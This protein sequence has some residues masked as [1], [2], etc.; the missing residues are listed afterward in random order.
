MNT[1]LLEHSELIERLGCTLVHSLW[2]I[3]VVAAFLLVGRTT[4]RSPGAR[5]ALAMLALTACVVGPVMTFVSMAPVAA[6]LE[7]ATVVPAPVVTGEPFQ[8]SAPVVAHGLQTKLPG[9]LSPIAVP[10]VSWRLRL[11]HGLP[12]AVLAWFVGMGCFVVRHLGGLWSLHTLRT[13]GL[14]PVSAE[15]KE[16]F[17]QTKARLGVRRL[18]KVFESA[19][20]LTP[21]V[22]GTL[23]PV[24]LLPCSALTGL[25]PREL[26]ALLTHEIAHLR[27]WD[28]LANFFQCAVETLLFF[29]PALWWISRKVRE[30]RELCCDDLAVAQGV[31][32][33][34]LAHALGHMALW[35]TEAL[36][37]SLAATG[38]M[39]VLARIK[40]LL[41]HPPP[42]PIA[43]N[44][45]PLAALLLLVAG[46]LLL[47]P[48]TKAGTFPARGRILDRNGLV[49]AESTGQS[50][51]CYPYLSLASH[52]VGYTGRKSP[53]TTEQSGR[54]GIE[55]SQE[56]ILAGNGDV[57]LS[58]DAR[59]QQ[60]AEKAMIDAGGQG[61]C[62]VIDPNNGD[63]L[64]MA[65]V[66]GYDLNEFIPI[67][68]ERIERLMKDPRIPLIGRSFQ[69][70]YFPAS[71]FKLVTALAGLKSGAIGEHTM[72]EGPSAFPIGDRVFHNWNKDDEGPLNL[73][74]AMKRSCNTWFYQAAL[75]MGASP[76]LD[77]AAQLGFGQP[78]GLPVSGEAKGSLPNDASYLQHQGHK[79]LDGDLAGISTGQIVEVSP[80]QVAVATASIA[81]GGKVWTPRLL[82]SQPESR[83][84]NNLLD[85]GVKPK[86]LD[87]VK[88]GMVAVVNAE[89]G[90]GHRAQVPGVVVAG[91][92]GTAQ[93]K[94]YDDK[95]RNRN[96]AW[97]T[98]FAPADHPRVAFALVYEGQPGE[99]VSG[100]SVCGPMVKT[101]VEQS[102]AVLGGKK[103]EVVPQPEAPHARILPAYS[104]KP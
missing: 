35:Q 30:E 92:T 96:L 72:F 50:A 20:V 71:T 47:P 104:N 89:D 34:D 65:S 87:L 91:K 84:K 99:A 63:L 48:Q 101:I 40:R 9:K 59:L 54:T 11:R 36:Q 82:L 26:E 42:S 83:L 33:R 6:V 68:N 7:P 24:V 53:Q 60:I 4:L 81:N 16:V 10:S 70:N 85:H 17:E 18:V 31:E 14:I 22:I 8:S 5:Y 74:G 27:R 37:P 51:R 52:I 19:R 58:L 100:G 41:Q 29:H 77:M 56:S 69:G 98:G 75:K 49:L 66:P 44:P 25:S 39:P 94:V 64:A 45:W 102:L 43:M 46:L 1:L 62:V 88:K 76:I 38:H 67:T 12:W 55:L 73:E 13:H 86:H 32:R 23:K 90:T 103:Y 97:F 15:V 57:T 93:W 2:Q 79:I 21:M 3:T 80:L 28:D 78:T 61:A 95:S